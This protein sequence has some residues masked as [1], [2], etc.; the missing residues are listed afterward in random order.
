MPKDTYQPETANRD[1]SRAIL[2]MTADGTEDLE[3]F[4]PYYRFIEAG[5]KVD[6]VTPKGK[7]FKAIH[8]LGLEETM[9]IT[10]VDAE[11]YELLYIPGGKAPAEL[12]K[13]KDAIAL[14]KQFF[15]EGMPI[16]A[17]C[18]GPQLLA[19]ADIIRG[20]KIAGWPEIEEEIR[21]AGATYVNQETVLDGPFITARWPGDLPMHVRETLAK[22]GKYAK[23]SATQHAAMQSQGH[24][25]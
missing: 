9:K 17:V 16:S 22:L 4:Y 8:E 12:M 3:F 10:D 20:R 14:T 23:T 25:G 15:T 11:D 6:V 13:N 24:T 21:A 19:A 1:T 2:M 7:G 5:F 18:H